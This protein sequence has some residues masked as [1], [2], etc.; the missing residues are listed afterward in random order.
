MSKMLVIDPVVGRQIIEIGEDG[1]YFDADLI[2]W[3]ERVDGDM[4]NIDIAGAVRIDDDL[5]YNEEVAL[6]DSKIKAEIVATENNAR[7]MLALEKIDAKS[8]RA[9]REGNQE[10][11]AALEAEAA[12]LRLQLVRE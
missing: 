12:T 5:L 3:D 2:L 9:L 10:R 11:I 1:A 7:I 8:I 4:P 6:T